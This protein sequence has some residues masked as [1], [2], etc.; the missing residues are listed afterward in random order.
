M[1]IALIFA[2]GTGQRMNSKSK[3]K[4]FIEL[5]GCPIIVYTLKHFQQHEEIDGIVVVC[6]EEWI[7]YLKELL[8]E[9]NLN[10]VVAVVPGGNTGQESIF[11]GISKAKEL[12]D[13]DSIVLIHDGVR[14]LIN[15]QVISDNIATAKK[16]GSAIT[17]SET[18]ETIVLKD[19]E[20]K[21]KKV[22][23]RN[24]CRTAKAPQ[25]FI[26]NDIYQA[27]LLAQKENRADMIDSASLMEWFGKEL[28]MVDGPITNIK[29]TTALDFYLFRAI[30]DAKEDAQ[31][32][33]F[34]DLK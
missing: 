8:D 29:I 22:T 20:N 15:E 21:V 10:K 31:I 32:Y 5:H 4:Q 3:P 11:K 19:N 24:L 2:G 9:Y 13:D 7:D 30:L 23:D 27:H 1:N 12:Y 14:P 28:Y 34:S 16:Y 25:S 26:L 6:I 18:I 33:G 17:T